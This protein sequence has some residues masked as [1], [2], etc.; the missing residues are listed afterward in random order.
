MSDLSLEQ[1]QEI[2]AALLE[3]DAVPPE[4]PFSISRLI[5][6]VEAALGDRV[7]LDQLTI[8]ARTILADWLLEHQEVLGERVEARPKGCVFAIT[9]T[10][11][12]LPVARPKPGDVPVAVYRLPGETP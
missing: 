10:D 4:T 12:I 11:G 8:A 7:A 3:I 9:A 1:V 6:A 2:V 5:A